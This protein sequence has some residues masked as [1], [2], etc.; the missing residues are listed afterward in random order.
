M[1]IGEVYFLFVLGL[2]YLI[3]SSVQDIKSREVE[4]WISF[5]LISVAFAYRAFQSVY[6]K[7]YQFI[8]FGVIGFGIFYLL[9]NL[10]YY[11]KAFGG[12]DVKLLMGLGVLL[13]YNSYFEVFSISLEFVIIL[14]LMT[15]VYTLI[16]SF[17]IAYGCKEK[18][19]KDI[20]KTISLKWILVVFGLAVVGGFSISFIWYF[21]FGMMFFGYFLFISLLYV[22]LKSVDKCMIKFV[23]PNDLREGDWILGDVKLER[24]LVKNTAHGLSLKDIEMLRK[25]KKKIVVKYG[26]PFVPAILISWIIMGFFYLFLKLN[27][28]GLVLRF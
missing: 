7:D 23:S 1:I 3:V 6:I 28:V 18:V 25:A 24:Y 11:S 16:Y 10:F 20:K 14:F 5:G 17:F 15:F 9:G 13:P 22:Y 19:V 4:N 27:L 8:F 12:A 21:A 26:I 2:V